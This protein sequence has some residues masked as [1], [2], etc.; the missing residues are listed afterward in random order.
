MAEEMQQTNQSE[1]LDLGTIQASWEFPEFTAY[2]RGPLWYITAIIVGI[3]LIAFGIFTQNYLFIV[4]IILF[5]IIIYLRIQRK[6][7]ILT[8]AIHDRGITVGE[9]SQYKWSDINS[10]WI[11]YEPPEVKNLYIDFKGIRP[12]ITVQLEDQNP[13]EIRKLLSQFIPE[14]IERENET[15]SDGFSRMFKL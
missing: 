13:L 1:E 8:I 2:E 11:I 6:P 4:L 15:F 12:D 9:R 3:A 7:Q 14:D 10:F 5:A